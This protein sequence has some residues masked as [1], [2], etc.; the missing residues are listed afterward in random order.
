[1]IDEVFFRQFWFCRKVPELLAIIR[2]QSTS[3][4]CH[5]LTCLGQVALDFTGNRCL[6]DCLTLKN[7][8]YSQSKVA[9][10]LTVAPIYDWIN[11]LLR[12]KER[13]TKTGKSSK[14]QTDTD[15]ILFVFAENC[16]NIVSS[17]QHDQF[18]SL[19]AA[20]RALLLVSMSDDLDWRILISREVCHDV[21]SLDCQRSLRIYPWFFHQKTCVEIWI[22]R[23]AALHVITNFWSNFAEFRTRPRRTTSEDFSRVSWPPLC[24]Y[25]W[26]DVVLYSLSARWY[27]SVQ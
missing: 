15:N 17:F 3:L 19:S 16:A 14:V 18:R 9:A 21:L 23:V 27:S 1:M 4:L 20:R 5:L 2:K 22:D 13:K 10:R 7:E 24:P 25:L 11:V 26:S 12:F 6:F 8:E